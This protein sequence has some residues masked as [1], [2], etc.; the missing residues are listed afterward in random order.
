MNN[1]I[2]IYQINEEGDIKYEK[3]DFYIFNVS[4]ISIPNVV[5]MIER[6]VREGS[7]VLLT[8]NYLE[9][10]LTGDNIPF[11]LGNCSLTPDEIEEYNNEHYHE[12]SRT[13][14]RD[15]DWI[16]LKVVSPTLKK[17]PM[18]VLVIHPDLKR[19]AL[20]LIQID[21]QV[22]AVQDIKSKKDLQKLV[23]KGLGGTTLQPALDYIADPKNEL[24]KYNNLILTDGYT[25]N[26]NFSILRTNTL[27][28]TTGT[29]PPYNDPRGSVKVIQI[30][31]KESING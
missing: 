29:K 17:N 16:E 31:L 6:I 25:D 5:N 4:T 28:L 13:N 12:F 14:H 1:E 19:R 24:S 7:L 30:D 11:Y 10:T 21:T 2:S 9:S 20:N 3:G 22:K 15:Y 26:L 18:Y 27:I 23:I 8:Y